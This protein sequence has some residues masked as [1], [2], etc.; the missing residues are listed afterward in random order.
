M[1]EF[2]RN[3]NNSKITALKGEDLFNNKLLN[4]IRKGTVFPAIRNDYICFYTGNSRPF[5]F[6]YNNEFKA[7]KKYL[8]F[9]SDDNYLSKT[10]LNQQIYIDNFKDNY[11]GIIK[12]S[13][14]YVGGEGKGIQKLFEYFS[15]AKIQKQDKDKDKDE[16]KDI[17]ILDNEIAFSNENIE[18]DKTLDKIDL[19]LFNKKEKKLSFVE[20]K[21]FTNSEIWSKEGTKP[22]VVDQINRYSNNINNRIDELLEQYK[23]YIEAVNELFNL[24]L[25]YPEEVNPECGL[26][27]FGFDQDQK[28]GRFTRLLK[29]DN[30]LENIYYYAIGNIT[31]SLE[32]SKIWD[33]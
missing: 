30:S 16:G 1:T 17:V 6:N 14:L 25:P 22:N 2:K 28:S 26:F 8:P 18:S 24:E 12:N 9:N 31:S 3:F 4:D 13:E 27:I 15:Y 7:H 19:L 33:K 29:K 10:D 11:R 32:L 20:V 5:V 23:K 21:E